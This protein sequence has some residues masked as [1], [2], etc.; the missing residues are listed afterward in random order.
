[1]AIVPLTTMGLWHGTN[2]AR[3]S[4]CHPKSAGVRIHPAA[5]APAC[6]YGGAK[7]NT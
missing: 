6:A 2:P 7:V 1:M 3:L 5:T 4:E